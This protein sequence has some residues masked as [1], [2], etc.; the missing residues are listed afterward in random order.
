MLIYS[1]FGYSFVDIP[2][3]ILYFLPI[4][5]LR[6]LK[7]LAECHYIFRQCPWWAAF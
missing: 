2:Q 7:S 6:P 5:R 4:H 1:F 3:K